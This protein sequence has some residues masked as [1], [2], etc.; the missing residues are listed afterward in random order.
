MNASSS[1]FFIAG[2]V[3]VALLGAIGSYAARDAVAQSP[4]ADRNGE[5]QAAALE[6]IAQALDRIAQRPCP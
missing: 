2:I 5:R 3:L 6:R 1:R 4:T